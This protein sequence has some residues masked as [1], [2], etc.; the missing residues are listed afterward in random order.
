VP[1]KIDAQIHVEE[2]VEDYPEAIG[3]LME[4]GI[5]CIQCGE[6]YWGS[7]DEL[8]ARKGITDPE[9]VVA[10]LNRYLGLPARPD[11]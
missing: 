3:F 10:D 9:Q 11:E 7:L 2:L 4:R 5:V 1:N 8:M 6:P